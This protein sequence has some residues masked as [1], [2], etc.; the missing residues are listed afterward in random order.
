MLKGGDSGPAIV[1][2]NSDESL[3]ISALKYDGYE[4]PP[5]GKLPDSVISDFIEWVGMGSPDPRNDTFEPEATIDFE[6]AEQFWSFQP[7]ERPSLPEV[8]TNWATSDLD[9]FILA[10]LEDQGLVPNGE[11]ASK[12][13]LIRRATFDL[14]G[15]ATHAEE[16]A[17]FVEDNLHL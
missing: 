14:I 15:F 17:D 3:L 11:R 5:K 9:R 1:P 8:M 12:R 7:V 13:A 4:M 2:G 16:I 10:A 6:E